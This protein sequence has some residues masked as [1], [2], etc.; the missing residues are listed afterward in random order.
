MNESELKEVRECLSE[1]G[2]CLYLYFYNVVFNRIDAEKIVRIDENQQWA[3]C[4]CGD[5]KELAE[6]YISR[7]SCAKAAVIKLSEMIIS[8]IKQ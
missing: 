4:E 6:A 7:E 5:R 3:Y 1:T 8:I 2:K